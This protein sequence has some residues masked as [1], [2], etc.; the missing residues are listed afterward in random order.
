MILAALRERG[1][2]TPVLFLTAR[3][4]VPDRVS[5]IEVY[6][7]LLQDPDPAGAFASEIE[8]ETSGHSHG[9]KNLVFA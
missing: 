6:R 3:D 5:K 8:H 2:Q 4:A 1:K 9:E 7:V